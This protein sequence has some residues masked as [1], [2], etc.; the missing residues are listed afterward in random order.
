METHEIELS[1][2]QKREGKLR[3]RMWCLLA[4]YALTLLG[5]LIVVFKTV[6][7]ALGA[8]IPLVLYTLVF[9]TWRFVV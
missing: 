2:E 5:G 7:I 4:L 6:M 1:V 9:C 8:I 3:V